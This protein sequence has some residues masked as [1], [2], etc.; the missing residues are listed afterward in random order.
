MTRF[1]P[2][3]SA[4]EGFTLV[5]DRPVQV[6]AWSVFFFLGL[7]AT[8]LVMLIGLGPAF[9]AYAKS[10]GVLSGDVAA[11]SSILEHSWPSF[12][13][14]LVV[15]ILVWS[16]LTA[17]ICRAVLRPHEKG[18]AY[19]K[20]GAD[21]IRLSVVN[22]LL[23]GIGVFSAVFVRAVDAALGGIPGI[24]AGF[25]LA[26]AVIWIGVRLFLA[27]PMTF[28]ERRIAIADSWRLTRGH[29][30]SLLGMAVLAVIF[31]LMVW[32]VFTIV[33]AVFVAM[34]GGQ[35]MIA[36]PTAVQPLALFAFLVTAAIQLLLPA[37]QIV[38]LYSPLAEAYRELRGETDEKLAA[39]LT[40]AA[41]TP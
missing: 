18:L 29:F 16:T 25:V 22:A 38:L 31:Y 10:N 8:F 36:H 32:L 6:L 33:S 15:A 21:E 27:T 19:L 28:A 20:F 5:R 39:A 35:D 24:L 34:A 40:P 41:G 4:L 3:E 30:W 13:L 11:Y 7:M 26:G 23:A 37:L 14:T 9:V 2:S 17:A 1:S 12:V